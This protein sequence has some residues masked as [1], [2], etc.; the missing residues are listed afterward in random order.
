MTAVDL[1]F[2]VDFGDDR[3][4]HSSSSTLN[5]ASGN[6][7]FA[8]LGDEADD[9]PIH[10]AE[11]TL[12]SPV[13]TSPEMKHKKKRKAKQSA[14]ISSDDREEMVPTTPLNIL[15]LLS[16]VWNLLIYFFGF[17]FRRRATARFCSIF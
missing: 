11:D 12:D 4:F 1:K 2:V 10:G 8:L 13:S 16:I 6:N 9:Q 17:A 5:M 15:C 7:R 3:P 14:E